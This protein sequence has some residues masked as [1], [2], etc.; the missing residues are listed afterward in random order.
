MQQ[1]M[2]PVEQLYVQ[3]PMEQAVEQHDGGYEQGNVMW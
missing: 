2:E 1:P 3:Q